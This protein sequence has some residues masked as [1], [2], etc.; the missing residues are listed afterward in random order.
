MHTISLSLCPPP[1]AGVVA[2]WGPSS[3]TGIPRFPLCPSQ[4]DVLEGGKV[5]DLIF[6]S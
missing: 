3:A 5:S 6:E 2:A 1:K 4:T